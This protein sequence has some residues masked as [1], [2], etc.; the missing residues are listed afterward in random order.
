MTHFVRSFRRTTRR[1]ATRRSATRHR[2]TGGFTMVELLTVIAI[3]GVL[4]SLLLP[5]VQ[6]AREASRTTQCSSRLRQ[7]MLGMAMHES[8]TKR[9]PPGRMGCSSTVAS[10]PAFPRDPCATLKIPNRLCGASGMVPIL[11]YLEQSDLLAALDARE[12]GLWVDNLN[13]PGWIQNSTERKRRALSSRPPVFVC[14][15]ATA[16]PISTVYGQIA[17]AATTSYALSNGQ[18]G[19]DAEIDRAKYKNDGAF[20]YAKSRKLTDIRDGLS[21]TLFIGEVT[22][23]DQ[24]E[25]SN[26]WT[27]GRVHSD[28]LRSTRNPLNTPP[29]T[30]IIQN[31]RNGAF[32]SRHAGGGYFA[33]GD[34]HV[35]FLSDSIDLAVYQS[36]SVINDGS[37]FPAQ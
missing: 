24:W 16:D 18:L 1:S 10:V 19:P 12:G 32:G 22:H 29:G 8:Q 34:G 6:A 33:F 4:V 17:D 37:A 9:F 2:T 23:A 7:I 5:A 26:I 36:A 30:G 3:T 15:S 25:S 28:T 31:R 35:T 20:I 27:Y 13:Q 14:P 11:P 21:N